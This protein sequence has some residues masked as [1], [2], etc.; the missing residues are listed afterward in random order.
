MNQRGLNH[1]FSFHGR[2]HGRPLR[3]ARR[4]LLQTDLPRLRIELPEI[5][6]LD[7]G[8]LFEPPPR[9]VWLEIGFGGGEHLAWQAAANPGVGMIGCEPY[10]NGVA[11]LLSRVQQQ[12]LIN[13][14]LFPDD[15][16]YLLSCLA[17]ASIARIFILFPDPWPKNRHHKRRLITRTTLDDMADVLEDEAEL[18]FATDDGGYLRWTLAAL[19]AHPAF[20]WTARRPRDW[21]ERPADWPQTR[22]EQKALA[23]GRRCAYL[24]FRRRSRA[25]ATGQKG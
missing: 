25:C 8:P 16:R 21:R 15:G 13:L 6:R 20:E 19:L 10:V 17:M 1:R 5:G 3:P 12:K 4:A 18:R 11:S 2:R 24:R 22:Y 7:P 14:R 23:Q 9:A